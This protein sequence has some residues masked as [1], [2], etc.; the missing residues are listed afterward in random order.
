[1]Y[2][3]LLWNLLIKNYTKTFHYSTKSISHLRRSVISSNSPDNIVIYLGRNNG[4]TMVF[5]KKMFSGENCYGSVAHL[6]HLGAAMVKFVGSP[7]I[8][9]IPEISR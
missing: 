6:T 8:F 9:D 1:M 7:S 4:V 3:Y 2:L 5:S